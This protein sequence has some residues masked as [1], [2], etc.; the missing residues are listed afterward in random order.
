MRTYRIAA[1][2]RDGIGDVGRNSEA[3]CAE[4]MRDWRITPCQGAYS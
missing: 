2:P 3:H 4:R 1:I